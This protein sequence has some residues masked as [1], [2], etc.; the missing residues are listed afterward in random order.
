MTFVFSRSVQALAV[1]ATFGGV[2]PLAGA[3]DMTL[4]PSAGSAT[5]IQSA[6]GAAAVRVQPNGDVQLP[7]IAATPA[8]GTTAVCHDA[9]GTL[10]RCDPAALAGVQ[11]PAGSTGP[12]GPQGTTGA[13]GATGAQGGKGDAWLVKA[14]AEAAGAN[15]ATGGQRLDFGFDS[16]ANG[17]LEPGEVTRTSYVCNGAQGAQ[18]VQGLKGDPGVGGVTGL[19]E[20]R[21]GCFNASAGV[22][23]GSGYAVALSGSTYTVTFSPVP[24][25]GNYTLLLD[26]RTSTGRA[27]A[28]T[29]GGTLNTGVT[30]APG[31]L[32]AGGET[33][34]RICFMVAR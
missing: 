25:A 28:L 20:V 5:I 16:S 18:G 12:A 27:L 17:A 23:S 31:W 8:A 1:I 30:I 33:V 3:A 24:G 34:Q 32:D 13:T 6:A 4:T 10:G 22:Q 7:G 26:G 11:G 2:T 21:H 29:S 15:C 19:E 9:N 14:T